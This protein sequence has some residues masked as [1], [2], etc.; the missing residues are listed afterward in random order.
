MKK[1]LKRQIQK[2]I[3]LCSAM[4][5]TLWEYIK[6][7]WYN[8]L[9]A[10]WLNISELILVVYYLQIE[11][12]ISEQW[13]MWCSNRTYVLARR[14]AIFTQWWCWSY[15]RSVRLQKQNF[16][17]VQYCC[18]PNNTSARPPLCFYYWYYLSS[19]HRARA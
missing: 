2:I 12:G 13:N 6:N 3:S 14:K 15:A 9:Y 7:A 11:E 1:Y 17:Q 10:M 16:S 5:Q 4:H 18:L 19:S 8:L